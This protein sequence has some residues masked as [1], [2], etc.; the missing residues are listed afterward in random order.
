MGSRL[1]GS[2]QGSQAQ[3]DSQFYVMSAIPDREIV[4]DPDHIC[5]QLQ[6]TSSGTQ[7]NRRRIRVSTTERTTDVTIGK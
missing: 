7:L 4:T 2:A 5:S 3:G 6:A 1:R